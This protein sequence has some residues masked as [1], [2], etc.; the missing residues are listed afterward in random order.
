VDLDPQG[1][2]GF[3]LRIGTSA[4]DRPRR[5][6]TGK[7]D[8]SEAIRGS[9]FTRLD[10]LPADEG[11]RRS[12]AVL[13]GLSNRRR[14]LSDLLEPCASDYDLVVLDCPP[15]NG[16]LTE[17]V[18]RA[19][20]VVLV[21]VIPAA[22]SI[23]TVAPLRKLAGKRAWRIRPF[24]SMRRTRDRIH[25]QIVADLRAGEPELLTTEIPLATHVERMAL[26]RKPLAY[27]APRSLV[28][29]AYGQL[30][31]ECAVLLQNEAGEAK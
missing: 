23:R 20:D 6:W 27:A 5:F 31:R 26:W 17:N 18:V 14:R 28:A 8:L 30:W 22:L 3:Q 24:I 29:K 9:D 7:Q 15:G 13:E 4:T 11:L 2:S 16:L 10:V 12:E 25:D 1:A 19:A 21:P